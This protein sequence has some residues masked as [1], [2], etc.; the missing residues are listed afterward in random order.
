M[1]ERARFKHRTRWLRQKAELTQLESKK[2]EKEQ[3]RK[4]GR[5]S[6]PASPGDS[7]KTE[8]CIG[9]SARRLG[10]T[11]L[12]VPPSGVC[13]ATCCHLLRQAYLEDE[14][15]VW[16]LSREHVCARAGSNMV[17]GL[18]SGSFSHFGFFSQ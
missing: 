16:L 5:N 3:S 9:S 14:G 1:R 2:E 11:G 8:E 7:G 17:R 4:L 13:Q 18:S 12:C 10:R 6:S 15:Q